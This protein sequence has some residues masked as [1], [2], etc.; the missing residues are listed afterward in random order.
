MKPF[1]MSQRAFCM[2]MVA[3]GLLM[4]VSYVLRFNE[5]VSDFVKGISAGIPIGLCLLALMGRLQINRDRC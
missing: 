4:G 5:D 2:L 3:G 1:S